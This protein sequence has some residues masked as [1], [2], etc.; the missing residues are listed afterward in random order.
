MTTEQ[1][2]FET[3]SRFGPAVGE[4]LNVS[5]IWLA[6]ALTLLLLPIVRADD[7]PQW[8]G[9]NRDGVWHERGILCSDTVLPRR[10]R[11]SRALPRTVFVGRAGCEDP[12]CRGVTHD[13]G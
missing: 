7:W 6:A 3:Q 1:N 8:R 11:P 5:K 2:A 9:P 13:D 12:A 10:P 4:E